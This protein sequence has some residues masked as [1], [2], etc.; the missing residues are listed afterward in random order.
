M[1]AAGHALQRD[2]EPRRAPVYL[3]DVAGR[4]RLGGLRRVDDLPEEV[5]GVAVLLR[6]EVDRTVGALDCVVE[7]FGAR[8]YRRPYLARRCGRPPP[9][10][11]RPAPLEAGVDGVEGGG[12]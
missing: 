1:R 2:H 6:G 10:A 11:R 7:V 9:A 4:Q 5:L 8:A 3:G 12:V